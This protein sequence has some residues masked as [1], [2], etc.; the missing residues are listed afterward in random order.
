MNAKTRF[1]FIDFEKSVTNLRAAAV[2]AESP[3]K[4]DGAIKRFELCYELAWKLMKEH[5][6]DAGIIC[7]TPRDGF[8]AA[9]EHDLIHR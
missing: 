5:L 9:K 7:K 4:I 2:E 3:L 1:I 8:K 6:S